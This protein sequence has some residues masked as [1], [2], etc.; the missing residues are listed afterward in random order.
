M[1]ITLSA[2][3][4]VGVVT[5][6]I[7]SPALASSTWDFSA[8]SCTSSSAS[9]TSGSAYSSVQCSGSGVSAT[10]EGYS[11]APNSAASATF[12]TAALKYWGSSSGF[13][14]QN[15]SDA[16]HSLD[17]ANG[18]DFIALAFDH[19][20]SLS[21]ITAG[22]HSGDWD[23][24]VLRLKD[25]VTPNSSSIAGN[26]AA[27]LTSTTGAWQ[28]VGHYSGQSALTS[29]NAVCPSS[30]SSTDCTWSLS[31]TGTSSWWLISAYN[32]NYGA[33]GVQGTNT[34]TGSDYLKLLA[35]AGTY[36]TPPPPPNGVPE[37]GSLAL[38]GLALIGLVGHRRRQRV[39]RAD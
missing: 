39:Q 20:V 37:P 10:L 3:L 29:S 25:G 13:G 5:A 18:T 31:N 35:V 19:E 24:S 28:L 9:L 23:I 4:A 38:A 8:G 16:D 15:P 27:Q 17:N 21:S 32:G 22:W 7:S 1:K 30:T 26:T 6:G 34:I 12:S 36:E 33:P 14:V 11:T 2:A